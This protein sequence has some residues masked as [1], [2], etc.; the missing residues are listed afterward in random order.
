MTKQMGIPFTRQ[1]LEGVLH[2]M[3]EGGAQLVDPEKLVKTDAEGNNTMISTKYI[4]GVTED[5]RNHT[6][7]QENEDST[8]L[9]KDIDEG[10]I[11]SKDDFNREDVLKGFTEG[12]TTY[13][14]ITGALAE[15]I[16]N[17]PTD[18][19]AYAYWVM[20]TDAD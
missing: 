5:M 10:W 4:T 8:T 3:A 16:K 14:P 2:A 18:Y 11:Q 12:G 9:L 7:N 13:P 19:W 15:N 1:R 6:A 17:A 20:A